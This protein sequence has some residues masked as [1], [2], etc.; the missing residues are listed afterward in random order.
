MC[1]SSKQIY[2]QNTYIKGRLNFKSGISFYPQRSDHDPKPINIRLEANYG[3][4]GVLEA[5]AIRIGHHWKIIRDRHLLLPRHF[6]AYK[7]IFT[8]FRS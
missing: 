3:V 1:I 2:S 6:M 5:G 4:L 8:C 7:Q